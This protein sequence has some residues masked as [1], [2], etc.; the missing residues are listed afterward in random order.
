MLKRLWNW[1]KSFWERK[2]EASRRARIALRKNRS[3]EKRVERRHIRNEMAK[4]SRRMNWGLI[5]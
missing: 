5:G 1:I 3:F 2:V 4:F